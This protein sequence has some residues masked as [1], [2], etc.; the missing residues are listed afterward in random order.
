MAHDAYGRIQRDFSFAPVKN[1]GRMRVLAPGEAFTLT[2]L[3]KS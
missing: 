1:P 2:R 3:K